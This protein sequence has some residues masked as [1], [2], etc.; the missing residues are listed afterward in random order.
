MMNWPALFLQVFM[1]YNS[2]KPYNVPVGLNPGSRLYRMPK[3]IT[4]NLTAPAPSSRFLML[5]PT[6][7]SSA[8]DFEVYSSSEV[9]HEVTVN[10]RKERDVTFRM[11]VVVPKISCNMTVLLALPEGLWL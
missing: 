10:L 7:G 4:F 8:I 1:W 9:T 2:A 6:G 3:N 11:E 5:P